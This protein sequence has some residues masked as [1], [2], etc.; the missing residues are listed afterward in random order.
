MSASEKKP[1]DK[2]SR[3]RPATQVVHLGRD[4]ATAHGFVNPPV[5]RGSTVLFPTVENLWKRDQEYTYGR[6]CTPT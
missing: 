6:T 3:H 2:K 5:Y 1:R 4:P